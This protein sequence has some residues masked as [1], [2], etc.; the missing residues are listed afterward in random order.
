MSARMSAPIHSRLG[1]FGLSDQL[2]RC[3]VQQVTVSRSLGGEELTCGKS[4]KPLA[5]NVDGGVTESAGARQVQSEDRVVDVVITYA[6]VNLAPTQA[7][8]IAHEAEF[9]CLGFVVDGGVV[10]KRVGVMGLQ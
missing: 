8:G 7:A 5:G 4:E 2:E 9:D 6:A 10:G 3:L 1:I